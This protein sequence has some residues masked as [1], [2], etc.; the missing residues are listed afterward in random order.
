[1]SFQC[2]RSVL[3]KRDIHDFQGKVEELLG[4]INKDFSS[5][6]CDLLENYSKTMVIDGLKISARCRE[7][8]MAIKLSNRILKCKNCNLQIKEWNDVTRADIDTFIA[9]LMEKYSTDG[10][11][12][13]YTRD[14]KKTLKSFFRWKEYGY[15][16]KEDCITEHGVGDPPE[17]RHVKKRNPDSK[18]RS[19]DL[20]TE[21]ER[22]WMLEACDHPMD[23]F[24][25]DVS[26]DAGNRSGEM[27]NATIGNNSRFR[28][29]NNY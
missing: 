27:F 13:E 19:S 17:T 25:I 6:T 16:S 22:V 14:F 1:M 26:Y 4:Q 28:R 20:L 21:E 12:T 11:E 3:K 29:S 9:E 2:S 18:L 15:R 7:L 5:D 24:M 10:S 23:V 8:D